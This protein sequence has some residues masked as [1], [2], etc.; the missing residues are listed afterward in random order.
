MEE[1]TVGLCEVQGDDSDIKYI[2]TRRL[3]STQLLSMWYASGTRFPFSHSFLR[4]KNVVNG[5]II[6]YC[7]LVWNCCCTGQPSARTL[8]G[9]KAVVLQLGDC[10]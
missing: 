1:G 10:C 7:I 5:Y 4:R 9:L 2:A 3:S 6:Q 8:L